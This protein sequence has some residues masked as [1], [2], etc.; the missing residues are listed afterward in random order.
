MF[1][2]LLLTTAM[3]LTVSLLAFSQSGTLKGKIIDKGTNEPV[4][5]ANIV[6]EQGGKQAGG[7]TTDFDGNYTIKPIQPGKYDLKATYVGYKPLM[8]KD[9]VIVSNQISFQDLSMEST[10][11]NIETFEVVDYKVPLIDK[12]QTSTGGT[13]TSEEISKMPGRSAQ[14]V[15]I[16]VGGVFSQ[17]GSM[18]SI[19][20]SRTDGTVTYVDGVRVR[21][22]SNVPKAAIEQ[23]T[24][25]TGGTPAQYGDVTGGVL[26]I[27]TKGASREFGIGFEGTTSQYLDNFGYNLLAFNMMGPLLKGKDSTQTTALLGYFIAGEY[28]YQKD[29]RPSQIGY[30]YVTDDML[31]QIEDYPVIPTGRGEG[32]FLAGDFVGKDYIKKVNASRNS[33]NQDINVSAKLDV[34]TDRKGNTNLTFGGSYN[35]N[36]GKD[37]NYNN[38]LFNWDNNGQNHYTNWRVFGRF[39]QRFPTN[40]ENKSVI[41]NVYYTLQG[42]YSEITSITNDPKHGDNLFEYGYLGKFETYKR[43]S[44]E[45]GHDDVLNMDAYVQNGFQDISYSFTPAEIN[46]ILANY[47]TNYYNLYPDSIGH[48]ENADQVQLGGGLLNGQL[49]DAI[50]G[51]WTNVGVPYDGYSF[52]KQTQ[53][54]IDA[55]GSADIGNHAIQIGIS[56]EQIKTGYYGYNDPAGL[57]SLMRQLINKHIEQLD[58]SNPH[59]VYDAYGVFMDT[60]NYDRLFSESEQSYFDYNFRKSIGMNTNSTEWIDIGSYTPDY[61]NINM[62]SA[63]ELLN[64]GSSYAYWAGYD[65]TGKRLKNKPSF[66]DFFTQKNEDGKFTRPIGAQEPIYMAGYIQDK[67]AFNDLIF[68][69]GLRVDRYDANQKVLKDPYLLYEAKTV[70][71]VNDLGEHPANMGSDYV[72][73]VDDIKNPTSILGYR[74]GSTWYNASGT[75]ISDPATIETSSG[76]APYLI[77]P[78]QNEVNSSAFEDYKPQVNYMPRISFSFP[79]SDEALFFAHYDV[80]TKR[81]TNG[82]FIDPTD[83]FF[84]YSKG[85]GDLLN[86]PN[87]KSEKTIDYELGFNQKISN[88]SS[89]KISAYYRELRNL[90][91]VYR[92][93]GAYPV[94]YNSYNNI[95][96]GTVKGLTISYDL[97]RTGNIWLRANY[98]LQ[99]ADGTGSDATSA[100][101]F[102]TTGQP[103][104]RTTTPLAYDRRHSIVAVVD[105]RYGSG[106]DYNGPRITRKVKGTDKVKTILLLENTGLNVSFN[107]GS[108]IPYSRSSEVVGTQLSSAGYQ[109]EGMINGSRMPWQYRIDARLDRDIEIKTGKKG[110]Q[111]RPLY[112]NVYLEVLNLLNTKNILSVYRATGNPEDDGYLSASQYQAQIE[113]Y[114]DPDAFRDQY[115]LKVNNLYNYSLPRRIRL[116]V[117]L[118]F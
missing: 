88:S 73:Y 116:G 4:P 65:Y 12:D 53:Y 106:K 60:I 62:F 114:S 42:S 84:I 1:R 16:T 109:L 11:I 35:Y 27:S 83:Y 49:P 18:G 76:I 107:V 15:A 39:T 36:W 81:P 75:Q 66:D 98:T 23:V 100:F 92:F 91:E 111:G 110:K 26:S 93:S 37:F 32:T 67:F 38:M 6:I 51:L 64:N 19:R 44:Y 58:K 50:N 5:F 7:T 74:N 48:W 45:L 28:T 97:R 52:L 117:Q 54:N 72:V 9:V 118:S 69:I 25:I 95:D 104:L 43:P 102:V 3:V 40:A 101:N 68:S 112:L 57:W 47:T 31:Q 17:D 41:K 71:E 99:F 20:G 21:G 61:F 86:N 22:S 113:A 77:D 89:I 8:V 59:A 80:L 14:S 13:M 87:L 34:R 2:K 55:N 33:A 46:P 78:N 85:E 30:Y 24:V 10:T 94:S 96:F 70:G 56:Y 115:A 29:P 105:Y 103:N 79:I 63:D 82:Q 90:V 108:G